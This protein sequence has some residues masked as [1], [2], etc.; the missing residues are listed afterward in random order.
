MIREKNISS[1][2]DCNISSKCFQH[3]YPDELAFINGKKIQ[4]VYKKGENLFKEGAFSPYVMYVADGLV[5]VYLQ[6]GYKKEV[7]IRL[8][9]NGDFL[10][11]SS[12]F[13]ND[14]FNYSAA[15]LKESIICMIDK[16]SLRILLEKNSL[17][18][19]QIL[20]KNCHDESY[21]LE[22]LRNISTKH[23][24]GKLATALLYLSSEQ[25]RG[26]EVFRYMTRQD[27]AGFAFI[28]PESAIKFIKEFERDAIISAKGKNID[29]LDREKLEEISRRG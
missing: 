5:R 29:V 11:F 3:L 12:L 18:A 14:V 13:G 1:C 28:S 9:R 27:I 10:A 20:S 15:A 4:L 6:A 7:N 2:R 22:A 8:A 21:L 17:F 16:K 25:F 26:L 19:M 23:M 24:R